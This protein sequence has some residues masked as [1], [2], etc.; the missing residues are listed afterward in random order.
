MLAELA[1]RAEALAV[2]LGLAAMGAVWAYDAYI[3]WRL[4]THETNDAHGSAH[5]ADKRELKQAGLLGSH[6]LYVGRWHKKMLR[7]A[8][9]RHLCTDTLRQGRFFHYSESAHL[10][11]QYD[12]H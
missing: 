11:G 5:W 6:G 8:T 1:A 12:R 9:D 3:R 7:L 4:P 2:P 10:S